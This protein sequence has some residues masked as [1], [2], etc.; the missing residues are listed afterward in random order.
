L[1]S[2]ELQQTINDR[3]Q[4]P[5]NFRMTTSLKY[6]SEQPGYKITPQPW[7]KSKEARELYPKVLLQEQQNGGTIEDQ[8]LRI[9]IAILPFVNGIVTPKIPLYNRLYANEFSKRQRITASQ[10]KM[11][12]KVDALAGINMLTEIDDMEE[13]MDTSDDANAGGENQINFEVD[14]DLILSEL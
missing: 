10:K 7:G 4:L 3:V 1:A 5:D 13:F 8:N 9:S 14:T 6:L 2:S 11:K 12:A